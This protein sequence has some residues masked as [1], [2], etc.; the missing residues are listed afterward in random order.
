MKL[1][2]EHSCDFFSLV[3]FSQKNKWKKSLSRVSFSTLFC[4]KR[5]RKEK[6]GIKVHVSMQNNH[7]I[8]KLKEK[9]LAVGLLYVPYNLKLPWG[10]SQMWYILYFLSYPLC[11]KSDVSIYVL[12]VIVCIQN[13]CNQRGFGKLD[14]IEQYTVEKKLCQPKTFLI[15]TFTYIFLVRKSCILQVFWVILDVFLTFK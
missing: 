10:K 8:I 7:L 3:E 12:C 14:N 15:L 5:K 1:G 4:A 9:T 11:S 2:W 13:T 6:G